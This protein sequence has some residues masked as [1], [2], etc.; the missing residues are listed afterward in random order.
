M[1]PEA[2]APPRAERAAM[3][4]GRCIWPSR[5]C[6]ALATVVTGT[7]TPCPA[8]PL[9]GTTAHSAV[10]TALRRTD[11]HKHH[12][13]RCHSVPWVALNLP[14]PALAPLCAKGRAA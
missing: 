6:L 13:K 11:V 4:P 14:A 9:A 2:L 8:A 3:L 1:G 12:P 10:E 7:H 5:A